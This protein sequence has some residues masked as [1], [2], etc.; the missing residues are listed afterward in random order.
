MVIGTPFSG[1]IEHQ[2]KAELALEMIDELISWGITPPMIVADA[3]YGDNGLFRTA[4]SARGLSYSV[5]AK[6]ATSMH[7]GNAIFGAGEYAGRG[8]PKKPG[9]QPRLSGLRRWHTPCPTST[10]ALYLGA[11][12][13]KGR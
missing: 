11:R 12:A 6:A 3:G 10:I 4:L 2:P 1:E 7:P 8:R 5:Q 13:V 9:Y